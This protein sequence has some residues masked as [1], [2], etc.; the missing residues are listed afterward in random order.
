MGNGTS[1]PGGIDPNTFRGEEGSAAK[2]LHGKP[3]PLTDDLVFYC[4]YQAGT[5]Y[6]KSP[7]PNDI[8]VEA[9]LLE[10]KASVRPKLMHGEWLKVDEEKWLPLTFFWGPGKGEPA[11]LMKLYDTKEPVINPVTGRPYSAKWS[12]VDNAVQTV[13]LNDAVDSAVDQMEALRLKAVTRIQSAERGRRARKKRKHKKK[14]KCVAYVCV[15]V[16]APLRGW[17]LHCAR[18]PLESAPPLFA[19]ASMM[20][21]PPSPTSSVT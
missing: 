18:H 7:D 4:C 15:C 20:R 1:I 19:P 12:I 14:K 16:L 11:E 2:G 10:F 5:A 13:Q 3:E 8:N 21:A 17:V 9:G 6:R